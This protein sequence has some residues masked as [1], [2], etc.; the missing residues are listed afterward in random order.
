MEFID[1]DELEALLITLRNAR[2]RCKSMRAR[3][4][5]IGVVETVR[6][7]Q[8]LIF[9]IDQTRELEQIDR[10]AHRNIRDGCM[11]DLGICA[12]IPIERFC[13][14]SHLSARRLKLREQ[15][16]HLKI[17]KTILHVRKIDLRS[18]NLF[19]VAMRLRDGRL[20]RIDIVQDSLIGLFTNR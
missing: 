2:M 14:R 20:E 5:Q 3:T 19:E 4:E 6:A 11:S 12:A 17:I 13:I 10:D 7:F 15:E 16:Q 8:L 9:P 1:H 18:I